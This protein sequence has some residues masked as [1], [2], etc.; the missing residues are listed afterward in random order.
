MN[1][2]SATDKLGLSR[3]GNE[4]KTAYAAIRAPVGLTS[5]IVTAAQT[6]AA[7]AARRR[8][9][10]VALA[11]GVVLAVVMV[12]L[13][14][15]PPPAGV[16]SVMTLPDIPG[17]SHIEMPGRAHFVGGI[18]TLGELPARPSIHRPTRRE[19]DS[20]RRSGRKPARLHFA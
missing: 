20:D 4:L 9:P 8:W 10:A 3:P 16:R 5:A 12:P 1:K 13:L 2:V 18:P 14:R 17:L 19:P 11:A 7:P 15:Q 6:R